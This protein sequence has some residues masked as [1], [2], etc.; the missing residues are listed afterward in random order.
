M[1]ASRPS[2]VRVFH[3]SLHFL[4]AGWLASVWWL[5]LAEFE[6]SL[7]RFATPPEYYGI[8]TLITG[9]APAIVVELCAIWLA[10]W[11]ITAPGI[12]DP[13]R[14]WHHAFWWTLVPNLMLLGTAY[15]M[16]LDGG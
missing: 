13:R 10:R 14:E 9:A 6:Q 16:I 11:M 7:R 2:A 1:T 5:W 8:V 12:A 15:L 3:K 4:S